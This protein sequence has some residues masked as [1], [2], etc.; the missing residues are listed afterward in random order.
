M[1]K[2]CAAYPPHA[3]YMLSS[4]HVLPISSCQHHEHICRWDYS[5]WVRVYARYLDEQLEVYSKT[6]F[7]QVHFDMKLSDTMLGACS[8]VTAAESCKFVS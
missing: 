1:L 4:W 8:R 2:S 5:E 7:Y 3:Q 6:A